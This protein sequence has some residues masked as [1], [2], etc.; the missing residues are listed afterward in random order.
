WGRS[1]RAGSSADGRPQPLHLRR[2]LIGHRPGEPREVD[3]GEGA[4]VPEG[5]GGGGGVEA[6]PEAVAVLAVVAQ[7]RADVG[8]LVGERY[9]EHLGRGFVGGEV[10]DVALLAGAPVAL[11]ALVGAAL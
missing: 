8:E 6:L 1:N 7:R 10:V 9:A 11:A 2:E 4:V 3:V 5:V